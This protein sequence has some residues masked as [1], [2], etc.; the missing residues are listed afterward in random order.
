MPRRTA[1]LPLELRQE[2][3][4][5]IVEEQDRMPDAALA[6][7]RVA[8]QFKLTVAQIRTIE[9]EGMASDWPPLG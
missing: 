5:A 6:R 4:T 7:E 1:E 8:R 3:F 9:A 2:I